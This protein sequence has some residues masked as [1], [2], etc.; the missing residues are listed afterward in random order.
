M[1][2]AQNQIIGREKEKAIF[3]KL[4]QSHQAKFLVVYGQS[5]AVKAFA[6]RQYFQPNF[7]MEFSG[8]NQAEIHVQLYHNGMLEQRQ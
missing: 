1:N 3:G 2:S 7:V 4:L 5:R 6:V 8:V